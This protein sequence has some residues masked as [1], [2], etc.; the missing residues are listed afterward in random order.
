MKS[1]ALMI[2]DR[3]ELN[4]IKKENVINSFKMLKNRLNKAIYEEKNE[5]I[6]R[7]L[8]GGNAVSWTVGMQF[9]GRQFFR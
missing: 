1:D 3:F 6:K 4:E 8:S 7:T 5:K 2:S 9:F